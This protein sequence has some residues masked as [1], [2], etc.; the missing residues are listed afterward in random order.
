MHCVEKFH[1]IFY[2]PGMGGN[3]MQRLFGLSDNVF[4]LWKRGSCGCRPEEFDFK[5]K[6]KWYSFTE[7]QTKNWGQDAHRLPA[8]GDILQPPIN[9]LDKSTI[10]IGCTHFSRIAQ[11]DKSY[12][13]NM[14][15][16]PDIIEKHY[17]IKGSIDTYKFMNRYMRLD[18][19]NPRD[20]M[21]WKTYE[22]AIENLKLEPIDLE[23]MLLGNNEFLSEYRRVCAVMEIQPIQDDYVLEF[24]N[25][26][27]RLRVNNS[28]IV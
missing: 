26:W 13:G 18:R 7:E 9:P 16:A 20:G 17:Y 8:A 12:R 23:F 14:I 25:N 11:Y 24:W 1:V 10:A 22:W 6:W 2:L 3:F 28:N 21:E 5:N 4:F 27:L 15:A 19:A